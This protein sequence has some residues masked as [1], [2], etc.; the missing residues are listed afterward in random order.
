MRAQK[1][2]DFSDKQASLLK[3]ISEVC[4]YVVGGV[5][6]ITASAVVLAVCWK[7]I[8]GMYHWVS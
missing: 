3:R 5:L 6:V 2:L 7:I 8:V 1:Q 4:V